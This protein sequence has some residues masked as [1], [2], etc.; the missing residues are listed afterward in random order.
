MHRAV[1]SGGF[2][3]S[4]PC[5]NFDDDDDGLFKPALVKQQAGPISSGVTRNSGGGGACTNIQVQPPYLR[6]L[7]L[8][9]P[10]RSLFS[11]SPV[12]N[13]VPR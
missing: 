13:F 8:P 6:A 4:T 1:V 9:L 10:L 2:T 7:G 12:C 11:N 5:T 3:S